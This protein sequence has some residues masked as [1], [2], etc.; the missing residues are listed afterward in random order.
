[1]KF[2]AVAKDVTTW[3]QI[4]PK[5]D[6]Q[7]VQQSAKRPRFNA[8]NPSLNFSDAI[9]DDGDDGNDG[10]DFFVDRL[11]SELEYLNNK[12]RLAVSDEI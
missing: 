1:M 8:E 11:I 12:V 6:L 7:H 10:D 9:D 2:A 3:R 5:L 4:Q